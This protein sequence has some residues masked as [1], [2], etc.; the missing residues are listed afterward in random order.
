MQTSVE[1]SRMSSHHGRSLSALSEAMTKF[2]DN[3]TAVSKLS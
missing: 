3:L 1:C 2:S